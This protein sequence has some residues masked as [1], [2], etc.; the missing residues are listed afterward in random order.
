MTS[1]RWH[2]PGTTHDAYFKQN[3]K[4]LWHP[5]AMLLTGTGHGE[6]ALRCAVLRGLPACFSAWGTRAPSAPSC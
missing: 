1:M 3:P 6:Q 4:E 2:Y 5:V